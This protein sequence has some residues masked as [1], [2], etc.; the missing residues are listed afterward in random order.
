MLV[1]IRYWIYTG[2][3][4]HGIIHKSS[5]DSCN[6][7]KGTKHGVEHIAAD[8]HG[9]YS[10]RGVAIDAADSLGTIPWECKWCM[11]ENRVNSDAPKEGG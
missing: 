5:C 4:A 1:P 6:N 3:S 7:G 8:W 11:V 2:G 9:V 10:T